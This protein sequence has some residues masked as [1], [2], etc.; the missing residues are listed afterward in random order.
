MCCVTGSLPLTLPVTDS[1][2]AEQA[3]KAQY[4]GLSRRERE[5]VSW[6]VQGKTNREIAELMVVRP[7]TV[8]TYITRIHNKLSFNSRVQIATWALE[9]G[10]PKPNEEDG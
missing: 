8:E 1:L 9:A 7:R 2:S 3:A 6:V 4:G 10:L 5:V